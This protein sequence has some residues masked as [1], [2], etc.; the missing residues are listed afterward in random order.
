MDP[1]RCG[2]CAGIR[3]THLFQEPLQSAP[4]GETRKSKEITVT[5]RVSVWSMYSLCLYSIE[6]IIH[7]SN[8]L[9]IVVLAMKEGFFLKDHTSQHAAQTPHVQTVVIHLCAQ[10]KALF[11]SWQ[12]DYYWQ[13][14]IVCFHLTTVSDRW[15]KDKIVRVKYIQ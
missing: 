11:I 1:V 15:S 14:F 2:I 3:I 12:S 13:I 9:V 6:W 8:N 10:Y 7:F 5:C 4:T